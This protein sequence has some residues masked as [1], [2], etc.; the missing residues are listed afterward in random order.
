MDRN[1]G[2]VCVTGGRGYIGSWTIKRL[3]E[4]GYSVNTT[5][6]SNPEHKKDLSFLTSLPGASQNLQIFNADLEK[7]ILL[8]QQL[9]GALESFL[10]LVQLT[11]KEENLRK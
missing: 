2:R 10:L 7:R 5:I 1:K 6:R 9:K 4:N 11:L 8:L 3:L